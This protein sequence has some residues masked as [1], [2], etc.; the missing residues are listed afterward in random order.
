MIG[1]RT[2]ATATH[3]A[4]RVTSGISV[5]VLSHHAPSFTRSR[6]CNGVIHFMILVI[7]RATE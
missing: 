7:G 3:T 4:V 1:Y 5:T 6:C 2:V